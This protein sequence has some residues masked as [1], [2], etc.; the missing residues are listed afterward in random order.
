MR[1]MTGHG[2]SRSS[3]LSERSHLG[4]GF[5]ASGE[6]SIWLPLIVILVALIF[7]KT[8]GQWLSASSPESAEHIM[9]YTPTLVSLA[10]TAGAIGLARVLVEQARRKYAEQQELIQEIVYEVGNPLAAIVSAIQLIRT[11]KC[12][13]QVMDEALAVLES[14]TRSLQM[15]LDEVKVLAGLAS[16]TPR[17]CQPDDLV[18]EAISSVSH[19]S[20]GSDVTY[21]MEI[22]PDVPPLFADKALLVKALVN[23]IRN[24]VEA[25]PPGAEVTV[26]VSSGKSGH[27]IS[28]ID[29]GEGIPPPLRAKVFEPR[30]S[31]KQ[32]PGRGLGLYIVR[33]IVE[34]VHGGRVKVEDHRP[35]GT[36]VRIYLPLVKKQGKAAFDNSV[37]CAM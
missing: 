2:T 4:G 7:L 6:R 30:V 22:D 27:C 16:P 33:E 28:V 31:T 24:A 20:T 17:W 35:T 8:G 19:H 9:A 34:P 3:L 18:E 12:N 10:L 21:S 26:A 13:R 11:G 36:A 29:N 32:E 15:A 25:S 14:S 37:P 1:N 5:V 23:V